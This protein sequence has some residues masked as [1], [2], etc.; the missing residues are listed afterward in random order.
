MKL[1]ENVEEG[2]R[3]TRLLTTLLDKARHVQITK[4]KMDKRNIRLR[5]L[6]MGK[7]MTNTQDT[8]DI[9]KRKFQR[10]IPS[11]ECQT[12]HLR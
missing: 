12:I 10:T 3:N 2:N 6:F 1:E 9:M 8:T 11:Q 7:E 4:V 5:S